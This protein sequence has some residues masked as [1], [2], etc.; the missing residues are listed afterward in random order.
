MRI[1]LVDEER[2]DRTPTLL[3]ILFGLL[4]PLAA[5]SAQAQPAETITVTAPRT[6][7]QTIVSGYSASTHAPI[8]ETTIARTVDYSD[9][10]LS[11]GKDAAELKARV[12][13]AARDLCAELDKIYPFEGKDPNCVG[14]S[15]AKALVH[16][17]A[18]I[19]EAERR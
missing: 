14:E 2:Y 13:T 9:L 1:R 10:N 6:V 15:Y 8:E 19:A 12:R 11:R 3:L 18:A 5:R 16:V 4:L 7:R 17:D